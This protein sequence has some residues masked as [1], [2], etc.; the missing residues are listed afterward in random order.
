[1]EARQQ[2]LTSFPQEIAMDGKSSAFLIRPLVV[3]ALV[4]ATLTP[5][6][7]GRDAGVDP[8]ATQVSRD[9]AG[10]APIVLAQRCFNGRCF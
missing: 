2:R 6:I 5:T 7:L 3:I 8:T 4:A 10:S 1:V 9:R